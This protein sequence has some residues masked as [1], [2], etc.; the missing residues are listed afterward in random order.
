MRKPYGQEGV[1]HRKEVNTMNRVWVYLSAM[2]IGLSLTTL[3]F[4]GQPGYLPE[5]GKS[6]APV[7]KS[8][9]SK[10]AMGEVVKA[11]P[12]RLS[13]V[14][15]AGGKELTFRVAEQAAKAL[16]TLKPGDKVMLQYT[17]AHGMRTVQ[18]IRKG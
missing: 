10:E 6:L 3:V 2:L 16:V 8:E 18:E 15:K 4:G 11:D 14:I 12:A 7:E 17:E 1:Q 5:P 13:L 9:A